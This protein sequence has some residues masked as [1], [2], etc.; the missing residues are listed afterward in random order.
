MWQDQIESSKQAHTSEWYW[1]RQ[2]SYLRR[3]FGRI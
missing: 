3:C 2:G 1:Q